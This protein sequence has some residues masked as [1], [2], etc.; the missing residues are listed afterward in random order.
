MIAK[1]AKSFSLRQINSKK[2]EIRQIYVLL[3]DLMIG[4]EV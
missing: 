3:L 4:I 1:I 2:C